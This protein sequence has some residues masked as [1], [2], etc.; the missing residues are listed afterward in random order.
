MN[1]PPGAIFAIPEDG[2]DGCL[3]GIIES[4]PGKPLDSS[5]ITPEPDEWC[6][7][8]PRAPRTGSS[9][10]V[11]AAILDEAELM[12]ELQQRSRSVALHAQPLV[13]PVF[14]Q[15]T[16]LSKF[17]C[18]GM[19]LPDVIVATSVNAAVAIKRPDIGSLNLRRERRDLAIHRQLD[20]VHRRRVSPL[21]A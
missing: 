19:S 3:V 6:R 12:S 5:E 1:R 2:A 4:L 10:A 13:L 8:D 7:R 17:L 15:V 20:H 16:T 21:L 14:D 11:S 18:L 9:P